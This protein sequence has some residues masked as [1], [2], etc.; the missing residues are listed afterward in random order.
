MCSILTLL[1]IHQEAKAL[2]PLIGGRV[3]L[4]ANNKIQYDSNI[5][6]SST[7]PSSDLIY[8]LA[9]GFQFSMNQGLIGVELE[10]N[11]ELG[12]FVDNEVLNYENLVLSALIKYPL[13][14]ESPLD[15][16]IG[17]NFNENS[18]PN[19]IISERVETQTLR[20]NTGLRYK[21]LPIFGAGIDYS[22]SQTNSLIP[23]S[24]ASLS[25]VDQHSIRTSI[26]YE[27][28]EL[29]GFDITYRFR[30]NQISANQRDAQSIRDSER[31][32]GV[33]HAIIVGARGSLTSLLDGNVDLGVFRRKLNDGI[34]AKYGFLSSTNLVWHAIPELTDVSL[35]LIADTT[36]TPVN[37]S[38]ISK[39][40]RFAVTQTFSPFL[41]AE[42]M[43]RWGITDFTTIM[44][45]DSPRKDYTYGL[46]LSFFVTFNEYMTLS[47]MLNHIW[48]DTN[49]GGGFQRTVFDLSLDTRY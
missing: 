19:P 17:A 5:S 43:A 15:I 8:K 12:R 29:L 6:S 20:L 45:G 13:V 31:M 36:P 38:I 22:F 47:T 30:H 10:S 46:G 39:N 4:V 2:F 26:N 49:S 7:D 25:D 1:V 18:R 32:T 14:R 9:P 48:M 35:S 41:S 3:D 28:S 42:I 11:I 44:A 21:F 34:G 40:L 23:N 16:S 37:D 27:Y 33:D 24:G